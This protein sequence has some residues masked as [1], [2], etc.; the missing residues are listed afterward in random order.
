MDGN[1]S[2]P[3]LCINSHFHLIHAKTGKGSKRKKEKLT[4]RKHTT[5]HAILIHCS[6]NRLRLAGDVARALMP[7]RLKGAL[8]A[9]LAALEEIRGPH[10][11]IPGVVGGDP[12]EAVVVGQEADVVELDTNIKAAGLDRL[13]LVV[14][15]LLCALHREAARPVEGDDPLGQ[16]GRRQR[17]GRVVVVVQ[18]RER[19]E[20]ARAVEVD[21]RERD[22]AEV[23]DVEGRGAEI[24]DLPVQAAGS[25][26][27]RV[28]VE[29]VVAA[30]EGVGYEGDGP[31]EDDFVGGGPGAEVATGMDANGVGGVGSRGLDGG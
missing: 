24:R 4:A 28:A 20:A 16:V 8:I 9:R 1:E 5:L 15:A 25:G 21:V 31:R 29:D 12:V 14:D 18:A 27:R 22:E 13:D 10:P 19:A 30:V 2:A 23:A 26:E 17:V 6:N 11:R 3:C 7:H